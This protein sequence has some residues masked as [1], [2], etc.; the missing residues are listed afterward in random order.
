M[1]T[2]FNFSDNLLKAKAKCAKAEDTSDLNSDLESKRQ[3]KRKR[4]FDDKDSEDDIAQSDSNP[5]LQHNIS[6]ST[7][8]NSKSYSFFNLL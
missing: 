8:Q 4:F 7:T 3:I 5:T 2:W 1:Y 6:L